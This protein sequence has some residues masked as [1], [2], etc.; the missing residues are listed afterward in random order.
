MIIERPLLELLALEMGCMYL[1]DLRYLSPERREDLA[2]KLKEIPLR[3]RDVREWNDALEYLTG[4][5]EEKTAYKYSR[6]M[7]QDV[8]PSLLVLTGQANLLK[9]FA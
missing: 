5:P 8:S 2:R 3:E 6:D 9:N 4:A 7:L 1:S